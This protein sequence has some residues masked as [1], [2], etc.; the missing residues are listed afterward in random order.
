[1]VN[2]RA[3]PIAGAG[4]F[5]VDLDSLTWTFSAELAHRPP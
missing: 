2:G 4:D 5:I 1:V 3:V